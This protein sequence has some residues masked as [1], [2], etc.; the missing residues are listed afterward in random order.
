MSTLLEDLASVKTIVVHDNCSDGMVSAL[1][2]GVTLPHAKIVFVNYGPGLASLKAEDDMLFCDFAPPRERLDEF[3]AKKNVWVLDHH[4]TQKDV[5][6]AFG[7]RGRF[8]DEVKDPGVSGAVLA[9]R[10]VWMPLVGLAA[11]PRSV[12]TQVLQDVATVAGIRDTWQ[13]KS[14]RWEESFRQHLLLSFYP[15][16]FWMC[17][18]A[19]LMAERIRFLQRSCNEGLG[20]LLEEKAA[21][22]TKKIV[23]SAYL[24][25]ELGVRFAIL[26]TTHTSDAADQLKAD[27]IVGWAYKVNSA[28]ETKDWPDREGSVAPVLVCSCRSREEEWNVDGF[29]K[30][31]GGGGH[32]KAAGFS[33]PVSLEDKN[34]IARIRDLL[35]DYYATGREYTER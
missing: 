15:K 27:V 10:E 21:E 5:V 25:T 26:Q 17:E 22:T 4:R 7:E 29:A 9:F 24:F 13:K 19:Q 12:L 16:S 3:L 11:E 6:E 33:L 23:D 30:K 8:G 34:P 20:P 28:E 35:V 18:S 1:I 14:P 2:L 31:H 32:Q